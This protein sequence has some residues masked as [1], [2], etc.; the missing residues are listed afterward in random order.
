MTTITVYQIG[1]S[2]S[3]CSDHDRCVDS[4]QAA[5][6]VFFDP[7]GDDVTVRGRGKHTPPECA[8]AVRVRGGRYLLCYALV[9]RQ[10][11]EITCKTILLSK[12][13]C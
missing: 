10:F 12:V 4:T 7:H 6:L 9:D 2:G 11:A 5:E 8:S 3:I 13:I 1:K